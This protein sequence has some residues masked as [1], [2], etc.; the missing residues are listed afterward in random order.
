[1]RVLWD[2]PHPI[3]PDVVSWDGKDTR[4]ERVAAGVYF[5]RLRQGETSVTSK[6]VL[7]R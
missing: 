6:L 3:G 2:G 4:G 7:I 5:T 1:V